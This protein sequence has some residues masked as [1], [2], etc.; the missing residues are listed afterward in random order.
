MAT[1]NDKLTFTQPDNELSKIADA[2]RQRLL[3]KNDFSPKSEFYSVNHPD[4]LADGDNKGR[5]TANFLDVNNFKAGTR[6]DIE[7]RN[8]KIKINKYSINN[9]YYTAD[10]TGSHQNPAN[11]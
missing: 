9:Q 8:E 6:T 5:G 7:K 10:S 4:A 11:L 1:Q 3:P 2:E